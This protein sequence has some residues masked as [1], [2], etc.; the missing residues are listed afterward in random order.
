MIPSLEREG[1]GRGG[2]P[3]DGS[4]TQR[5]CMQRMVGRQQQTDGRH[6]TLAI[7]TRCREARAG[8]PRCGAGGP[9]RHAPYAKMILQLQSRGG[10][11]YLAGLGPGQ[12]KALVS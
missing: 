9:A 3:R 12:S 2:G 5:C 8:V 10:E 7:C 4:R 6:K 1:E 11:R